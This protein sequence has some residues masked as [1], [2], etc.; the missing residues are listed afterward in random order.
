MVVPRTPTLSRYC[1]GVFLGFELL[2]LLWTAALPIAQVI[3]G[4]S[5]VVNIREADSRLGPLIFM[6][7]A[8]GAVT[9]FA[10]VIF[11]WLTRPGSFEE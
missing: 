8:L 6:L 3:E 7:V 4:E 1:L 11:W 2:S 9:I 5:E 10:T